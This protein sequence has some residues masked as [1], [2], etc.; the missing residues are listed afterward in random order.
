MKKTIKNGAILVILLG[1]M[2]CQGQEAPDVKKTL[3]TA[4]TQLLRGSN[5]Y[6]P[7]IAIASY[8]LLA[9]QGNA[10]AMNALGMV[11][12]KGIGVSVDEILGIQWL[13]K[14]ANAGYTKAWYNL[15]ILCK[16]NTPTKAIVYFE[17]A[18]TAGYEMAWQ[19]WG[20]MQLKGDGVPKNYSIAMSIFKQGAEKGSASCIYS[21]GYM[22]YKGLG[23]EQ[24]YNKAIQ[25]FDLGSQKG[26]LAAIY[27]L[28][29]CYRNGYGTTIDNEK[30]KYWLN[31][32]AS[33]GYKNAEIELTDS[34]AENANPN[35]VKTISKPIPELVIIT[36]TEVPETFKKVKQSQMNSNV[37]GSY[38]GSVLLYDWSGQNIISTTPLQIDLQ[39]SGDQL[40]GEWKEEDSAT[41]LFTAQIQE[42]AIVFQ[43]SKIKR[44]EH[45]QKD[46]QVHYE[47]KEA[48]LQL[49]ETPE[50]LFLVGNI[51]LYNIKHRE[52]E[53]P[54]YL[55]L[56]KK[57]VE[58][59]FADASKIISKV[60]LYPNPFISSFELS[61]DLTQTTTVTA[62]IHNLSGTLLYT[63]QWK[64]MELGSQIKTISL[65]APSGYYLL[66]LSYGQEI[67]TSILIKQ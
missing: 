57:Q 19:K 38:I 26:N 66:R 27:M 47:F 48:R 33:K 5:S 24:D 10:E 37:S 59:T 61:F 41:S 11:Y 8:T 12:S 30:A 14:A 3:S 40:S 64:N 21:I 35:Q 20:A 25:Q 46:S 32:A 23:C 53:K 49:L 7:E 31:K 55:I 52:N 2:L 15:G 17:K 18:A 54:M 65:D 63:T 50:S 42:N 34:E 51:Q 44:A 58:N 43:D 60:M 29:L 4:R 36:E 62:S 39:Q 1:A 13:E 22:Y 45:Y 67:K 16:E 28:G 56:E 9:S 6:N